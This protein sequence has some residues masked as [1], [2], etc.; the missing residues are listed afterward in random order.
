MRAAPVVGLKCNPAIS[1]A[2][3]PTP[4]PTRRRPEGHDSR[5]VDPPSLVLQCVTSSSLLSLSL[6]LS[7]LLLCLPLLLF[8]MWFRGC[9]GHFEESVSTVALSH[10][11]VR[12]PK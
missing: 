4:A 7:L 12:F 10:L 5:V 1:L 9:G 8:S 2:G 6:L 11:F 3:R